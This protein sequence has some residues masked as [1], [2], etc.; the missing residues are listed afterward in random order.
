[1]SPQ[2][3]RVEYLKGDRGVTNRVICDFYAALI[4]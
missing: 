1:M 4:Q 3:G 2:T